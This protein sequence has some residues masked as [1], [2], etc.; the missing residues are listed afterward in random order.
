[1]E[2]EEPPAAEPEQPRPAVRKLGRSPGPNRESA[3]GRITNVSFPIVM[4]GYDREVVEAHLA[5]VSRLVAELEATRSPDSVIKAALD[6][7]GE[8]TSGILQRAHE[9]AEETQRRSRSQADDRMQRVEREIADLKA[10]AEE[11]LRRIEADTAGVWEERRRLVEDVRRLAEE[12]DGVADSALERRLPASAERS[13]PVATEPTDELL[14]PLEERSP[15][16]P[17]QPKP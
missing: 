9:A 12:L 10:R 15:A 14:P 16:A 1:M 4:R 2:R 17:E 7:V 5:E 6:D 8:Q 13:E 3:V 11:E